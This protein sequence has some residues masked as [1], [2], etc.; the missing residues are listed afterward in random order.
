[1]IVLR[2]KA[3]YAQG[4]V[5]VPL[6][7]LRICFAEQALHAELAAFDPDTLRIVKAIEDDGAAVSW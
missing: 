3:H 7:I 6:R 2:G 5:M 4:A 1:M